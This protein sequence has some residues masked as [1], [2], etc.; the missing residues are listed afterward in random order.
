MAWTQGSIGAAKLARF[1]KDTP[2]F[3][4]FNAMEFVEANTAHPVIE[5][6]DIAFWSTEALPQDAKSDRSAKGY[7]ASRAF[8]R[9][10]HKVTKPDAAA[11]DWYLHTHLNLIGPTPRGGSYPGFEFVWIRFE[12]A[13]TIASNLDPTNGLRI[14]LADD[15]AFTTNLRTITQIDS[16]DI[17]LDNRV[18]KFNLNGT[19]AGYGGSGFVRFHFD[20]ATATQPEITEVMFG[21]RLSMVHQPELPWDDVGYFSEGE[22]HVTR[23]GQIARYGLN[24]GGRQFLFRWLIDLPEQ[25]PTAPNTFQGDI[26][27]FVTQSHYFK[28]PILYVSTPSTSPQTFWGYIETPGYRSPIVGP[29]VRELEWTFREIAPYGA[30]DSGLIT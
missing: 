11:S 23:A 6:R 25:S 30:Q 20:F 22:D 1:E 27:T 17:G 24:R 15:A 18:V 9:Y 29:I 19:N 2:L 16:S 7:E 28:V 13:S 14:Q 12:N 26:N 5:L 3:S 10:T 8:D 21:N 4:S